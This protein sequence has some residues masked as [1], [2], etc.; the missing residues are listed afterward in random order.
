MTEFN[1]ASVI[2]LRT[3][4]EATFREFMLD[5]AKPKVKAAVR[6]SRKRTSELEKMLKE[7]RKISIK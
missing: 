1:E 6:R 7:Y 2:E 3:K 4:I 5:S